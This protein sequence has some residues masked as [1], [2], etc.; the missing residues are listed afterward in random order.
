MLPLGKIFSF[1]SLC[2]LSGH[3][4]IHC[5]S[6]FVVLLFFCPVIYFSAKKTVRQSSFFRNASPQ[7]PPAQKPATPSAALPA[8]SAAAAA[9]VTPQIQRSKSTENG[10]SVT[11]AGNDNNVFAPSNMLNSFLQSAT[12]SDGGGGQQSENG[13][14]KDSASV[15]ETSSAKRDKGPK[16]GIARRMSSFTAMLT[17]S[18]KRNIPTRLSILQFSVGEE[19]SRYAKFR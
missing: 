9:V 1:S 10:G 8:P 2:S 19:Y 18:S 12:K 14:N 7:V 13:D 15:S 4:A 11:G 6:Y 17:G 3:V 5:C 16:R